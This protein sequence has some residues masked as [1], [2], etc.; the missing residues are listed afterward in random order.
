MKIV[1]EDHLWS[2]CLRM[3]MLFTTWSWR[4]KECQ[5]SAKWVPE[6]LNAD[7]KQ[8]VASQ[9][10]LEHF[11]QNTAGFLAQLV[12]MDKT[13]LHLYDPETKEQPKEWRQWF[14]L[15]KKV[16]NSEVSL[17]DEG[18]CFLGQRWNTAGW[19]P[20]KGCNNHSNLLHISL[21]QSEADNGLLTVGKTVKR[22]AVS[23]GQHLLTHSCHHTAEVGWYALIS[24]VA[25]CLFT[26]SGRFRL[27]FVLK[28]GKNIWRGKNFRPLRM[29]CPL[30][31]FLLSNLQ[32]SIWMV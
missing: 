15:S 31:T 32:H 7:Q 10:I 16:S 1:Q 19:L 21:G 9:A 27:R 28:L 24:A 2:L 17:Q 5:L 26:W 8:F 20:R 18:I 11:R 30:Q 4:I 29:P 6:C 22:S 25:P 12:S 23:P 3:W 14:T 13:W